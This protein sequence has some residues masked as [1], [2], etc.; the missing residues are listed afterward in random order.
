MF[1]FCGGSVCFRTEALR[2]AGVFDDDFF[3][4]YEDTDLSWR[5]RSLGWRIR[6]QPAAVARHIHSASSVEWSPLFVFHTDR[7]RL[8]MLTKNACAG[9]AAREV[10]RYLDHRLPGPA[11]GRP[12]PPHPPPAPVRPTLLR[13][14]VLGSYLRLLPVM[15][16]RRRRIAARA[17]AAAD[18]WNAG[19]CC[20][21]GLDAT[22]P[23]GPR[24]GSGG[25][26]PGWPGT[27]L[28][29]PEPEELALVPFSWRGTRDLPGVPRRPAGPARAPPGPARLLQAAWARLPWPPV[30]WLAGPVEVFHGTNFVALPTRRAATVVTVHDL[31]YLRFPE[32]VTDASARY[33]DLVP[34]ALRRA[35]SSAPPPP[36][37]PPRSPPS[38]ASPDRLVVT[39]SASTLLALVVTPPDPAWL[40]AHGLPARYLLFVGNRE[41]RKNLAASWP[42]TG[43]SWRRRGWKWPDGG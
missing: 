26:W 39:P 23:L 37:S 15:L 43:T 36:P 16:V 5:L 10:L 14:R 3:L 35:R 6:Y 28:A 21:G 13:L 31:T 18:A 20:E 27:R 12:L 33:R 2:Q 17:S 34:R 25:M 4:Y 22:P 40:A 32:M 38:T 30:E 19:W 7:N 8:L 24:T 42:P 29:G 11:R 9:L 41:P 1:A